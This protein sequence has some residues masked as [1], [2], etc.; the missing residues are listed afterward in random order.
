MHKNVEVIGITLDNT[1][2][3]ITS[4]DKIYNQNHLPVSVMIN[5]EQFS[6]TRLSQWWVGRSI[7]ASR[8]GIKDILLSL[9]IA[10]P[11]NLVDK[12][13]GLSLSD[14]YWIKPKNSS[15]LWKNINF[16][17]NDFSEDVGNLLFGEG[18]T[19]NISLV[20]PDNTSDGWLKKK[21]KI[22]DN[23]R[24]LIKSGS[25]ITQQEPYNEVIA[26]I[27]CKRLKIDHIPY[28][29]IFHNEYPYS[30]CENFVTRDTELVSGYAIYN[31]YQ[32]PNHI[33]PYQHYIECARKLGVPDLEDSLNKMLVLDYII[34]N[35]DRHLNNFGVLRNANTLE[36]IAPAPVFDSGTSLWYNIPI[37]LSKKSKALSKPFK[38]THD[39]QIKL[40]TSFDFFNKTALDGVEEDI[41]NLTKNSIF[42][43]EVRTNFICEGISSRIKECFNQKT[44]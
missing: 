31:S 21:W 22:I 6:K 43:D 20:S 33:S 36:Y 34:C 27:I 29:L 18:D 3:V 1:T 17:D 10:T 37:A 42:I 30:M 7:P 23:K 8:M 44:K 24:Y 11:L 28:K 39:E 13:F 14:Q 38:S 15:L 5:G 12:A 40:V 9:D 41:R 35:Q 26:S 32:K 25:S 2:G 16:F 19:K 4:T